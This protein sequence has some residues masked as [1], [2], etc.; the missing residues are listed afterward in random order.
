MKNNL[1]LILS[2]GCLYSC[3]QTNLPAIDYP[4]KFNS[5]SNSVIIQ[6]SM[7]ELAWWKQLH[8][9]TLDRLI[10]SGLLNNNDVNIAYANLEQAR[11][12]LRQVQLSWIP[13][14]NIYAGF[15]QNPIFSNAGT[16][17]GIWPQYTLNLMQ[18]PMLQKHAKYNF[19]LQQAKIDSIKL[20]LIGQI[21][22]GYMTYL[23][24]QEQLQLLNTLQKDINLLIKIKSDALA[25]GIS[26]KQGIELLQAQE[27]Q[28]ISQKQIVEN[29]IIISQNSLRYLL[30]QNPGTVISKNQ[31]YNID[32]N[33]IE[34][35]AIPL[36]VLAN[37]PDMKVAE[38]QLR[39]ADEGID[40]SASNLFPNIQLDKWVG[41]QSSNGTI[42]TPNTY[43]TFN[44]AYLNWQVTPSVFG[45]IEASNGQYKAATFNYIKTVRQILRDVD[46]DFSARSFL[47]KKLQAERSS[48]KHAE[49]E[50][51]LQ[52]GLYNQGIIPYIEVINSKLLLDNLALSINQSKLQYLLVQ[53]LLYQ[54]LAGGYNYKNS[55]NSSSN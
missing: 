14:V 48:Y 44:D 50:Y 32:E 37:R 42:G 40:I 20:T 15:T 18:L 33:M 31:F 35:G 41:M 23:A 51:K 26:V 1:L 3:S 4:N 39:I 17:Y 47:A 55:N 11:G 49:E 38:M 5:A 10:E 9:T 12:Q 53:V 43:G 30:N 27:Q 7:P 25:G 24:Q 21:T 8:D 19:K 36:T 28:I 29:N 52:N 2:L 22:A 6:E 13:F 34:I 16:F 54:D 46:N 45:Q